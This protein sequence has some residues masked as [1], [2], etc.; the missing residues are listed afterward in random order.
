M[1]PHLKDV[2][3]QGSASRFVAV[4]IHFQLI[5]VFNL[6]HIWSWKHKQTTHK[7]VST[8]TAQQPSQCTHPVVPGLPLSA[9]CWGIPACFEKANSFKYWTKLLRRLVP[10]KYWQKKQAALSVIN[11]AVCSAFKKAGSFKYRINSQL[12]QSLIK[13]TVHSDFE[14]TSSFKY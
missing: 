10:F 3:S 5:Q 2:G 4:T 11:K 14:R 13:L 12:Y 9:A 7:N 8:C 1:R 6:T